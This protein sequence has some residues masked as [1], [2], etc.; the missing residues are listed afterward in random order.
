MDQRDGPKNPTERVTAGE[1]EIAGNPEKE[2]GDVA[3]LRQ[4][5]NKT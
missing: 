1:V 4:S 3:E 5:P 2:P